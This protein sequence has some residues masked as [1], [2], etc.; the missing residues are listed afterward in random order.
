MPVIN[1]D[2]RCYNAK[3]GEIMANVKTIH[4]GLGIHVRSQR[5][6]I[7]SVIVLQGDFFNNAIYFLFF[8]QYL[9]C[10][11]YCGFKINIT[12]HVAFSD[13]CFSD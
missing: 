13:C 5:L 3:L 2:Y 10:C 12:K 7:Y 11:F 4:Q 8:Y 9:I 6:I 1:Y